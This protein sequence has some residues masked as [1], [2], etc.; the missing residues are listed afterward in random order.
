MWNFHWLQIK[1]PGTTAAFSM[2]LASCIHLPEINTHPEAPTSPLLSQRLGQVMAPHPNYCTP[3]ST[4][5]LVPLLATSLLHKAAR[6]IGLKHSCQ[7][8]LFCLK[9]SNGLK[10]KLTY[11]SELA[12]GHLSKLTAHQPLSPPCFPQTHAHLWTSA[13]WSFPWNTPPLGTR[14][15]MLA[16][17]FHSGLCSN[18]AY[19]CCREAFPNFLI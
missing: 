1:H 18:V 2:S 10:I 4:P 15:H 13:P 11:N 8:S 9:A 16:P 6:E 19:H 7:I 14:S 5:H 12:P 17:Q 3:S